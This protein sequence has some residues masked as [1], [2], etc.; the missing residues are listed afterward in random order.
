MYIGLDLSQNN[1]SG[2]AN[3]WRIHQMYLIM[4]W[5]YIYA[6]PRILRILWIYMPTLCVLEWTSMYSMNRDSFQMV[7]FG[8][9]CYYN[10]LN[11]TFI[12]QNPNLKERKVML[13][14]LKKKN[15]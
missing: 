14:S 13:P 9:I 3:R 6:H 2:M 15:K 11:L 5:V 8:K 4:P 10:H 1:K 12:I 7:L